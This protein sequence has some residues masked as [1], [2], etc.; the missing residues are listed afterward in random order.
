MAPPPCTDT[1]R[2]Y[3]D[4]G[5]KIRERGERAEAEFTDRL[6]REMEGIIPGYRIYYVGGG[7][8]FRKNYGRELSGLKI[9]STPDLISVLWTPDGIPALVWF[10]DVTWH[11]IRAGQFPDY[12]VQASKA[13]KLSKPPGTGFIVYKFVGGAWLWVPAECCVRWGWLE[14]GYRT[15][16]G[17]QDVY[18]VPA[19]LWRPAPLLFEALKFKI[20]EKEN[21]Y[22]TLKPMHIPRS[23]LPN[24]ILI[25]SEKGDMG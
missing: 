18:H 19:E 11:S 1:T 15:E 8:E 21:I 16:Y 4:L 22:G 5:E 12:V 9:P 13:E 10:F 14:R 17:P 23:R 24:G 6:C 2:H 7:P 25:I 20:A 3:R